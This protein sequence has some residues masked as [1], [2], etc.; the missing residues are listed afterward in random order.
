[1][2]IY[3]A[4]RRHSLALNICEP[5]VVVIYNELSMQLIQSI[6]SGASLGSLNCQFRFGVA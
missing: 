4:E 6:V 3:R 2:G 1:M 5:Y